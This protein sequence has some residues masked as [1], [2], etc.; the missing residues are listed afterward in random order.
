MGGSFE[1]TWT[2]QHF[3][4]DCHDLAASDRER[5]I[6]AI[7]SFDCMAYETPAAGK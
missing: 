3:R 4:V 1:A 6:D 5:L 2:W 7:E